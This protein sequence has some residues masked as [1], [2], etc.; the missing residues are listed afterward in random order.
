MEKSHEYSERVREND[1]H[2][3]IGP[4]VG[5]TSAERANPYVPVA[6]PYY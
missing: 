3:G 2:I 5:S 6:F 1:R 4:L